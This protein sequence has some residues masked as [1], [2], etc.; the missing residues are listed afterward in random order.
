MPTDAAS[1]DCLRHVRLLYLEGVLLLTPSSLPSSLQDEEVNVFTLRAL[2]S[3]LT[4]V[5]FDSDRF[6]NFC[7]Q[8]DGLLQRMRNNYEKEMRARGKTPERL[9]FEEYS[10]GS[11]KTL[12]QMEERGK[13]VGVLSR[14]AK[15]GEDITGMKE[16][17]VY[18]LKGTQRVCVHARICTLFSLTHFPV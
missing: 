14:R 10:L 6:V 15:E 3:T 12:E 16:M 11:R 13:E 7:K 17:I 8:A 18:G 5:N 1:S 2:F 4:N 9:P